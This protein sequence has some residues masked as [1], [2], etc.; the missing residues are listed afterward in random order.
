MKKFLLINLFFLLFSNNASGQSLVWKHTIDGFPYT[1]PSNFWKTSDSTLYFNIFPYEKSR[2][3]HTRQTPFLLILNQDGKLL[4]SERIDVAPRKTGMGLIP[5]RDSLLLSINKNLRLHNKS[6]QYLGVSLSLPGRP[7]SFKYTKEGFVILTMDDE[8]TTAFNNINIHYPGE[9]STFNTEIV[10]T[11]PLELKFDQ[12]DSIQ[13]S[14][15]PQIV[16]F[17]AAE[18]AILLGDKN[19]VLSFTYGKRTYKKNGYSGGSYSGGLI[20]I[21]GDSIIWEYPKE[22][23][24]WNLIDVAYNSKSIGLLTQAREDGQLKRKISIIDFQGNHIKDFLIDFISGVP[25]MELFEDY[26]IV[27]QKRILYKYNFDGEE[28]YTYILKDIEWPQGVS[29]V[30]DH[31][32]IIFGDTDFKT[33]IVKIDLTE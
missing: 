31:Q 2:N 11:K 18:H 20:N 27:I 22:P 1:K 9:K 4:A 8:R 7:S 17:S 21:Q 29:K 13:S 10:K 3:G 28:Q 15:K 16:L 19:W 24:G 23:N 30:S 12:P 26:I 33:T 25:R 6:G 14:N 32:A 5:Y